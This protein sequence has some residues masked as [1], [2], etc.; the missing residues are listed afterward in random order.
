VLMTVQACDGD[1]GEEVGFCSQEK[2]RAGLR[3]EAR[4]L[5]R[6][7]MEV[8]TSLSA[9]RLMVMKDIPQPRMGFPDGKATFQG[10]MYIYYL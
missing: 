7:S 8:F 5:G 3:A 10:S 6:D 9:V 1:E 4:A 2:A